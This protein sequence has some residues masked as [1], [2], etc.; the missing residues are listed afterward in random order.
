MADFP[1]SGVGVYAV[2]RTTPTPPSLPAGQVVAT[3]TDTNSYPNSGKTKIRLVGTTGTTGSAI[4]AQ[5]G[6]SADGVTTA[7]KVFVLTATIDTIIGPFPTNIYGSSLS[8]SYSGTTAGA[9]MTAI[10]EP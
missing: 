9:K 3:G 1:L 2:T 10:D 5:T 8:F 4:L 7:G 6:V